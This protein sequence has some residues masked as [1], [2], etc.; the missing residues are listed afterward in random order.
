MPQIR[1]IKKKK[2]YPA[3]TL[4]EGCEAAKLLQILVVYFVISTL[5]PKR[6][7]FKSICRFSI[8][9]FFNYGKKVRLVVALSERSSC[10]NELRISNRLDVRCFSTKCSGHAQKKADERSNQVTSQ[11]K[12]L[13]SI[14]WVIKKDLTTRSDNTRGTSPDCVRITVTQREVNE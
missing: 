3:Q 10:V 13:Q 7:V 2:Q 1:F 8:L 5:N 11:P 14:P 4:G 9:V 6:L 12:A